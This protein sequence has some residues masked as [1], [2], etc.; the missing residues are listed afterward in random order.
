VHSPLTQGRLAQGPGDT[1]AGPPIP[2]R[3]ALAALSLATLLPSLAA[4]IANAGL[5]A[6]MQAFSASFPA[7]QW[8]VLGYLLAVTSLIVSIGRLGDRIGRRRLLLGGVALFTVA[9]GVSGAAPGLTLLIAAQAAQGF[10]AAVMTALAMTFVGDLV[11]GHK[12]GSA[13]GLLGA[14]SAIG[15]SLGPSLCGAM[16]AGPGWRAIFLINVPLGLVAFA[17]ACRYL[18]AAKGAAGDRTGFDIAGTLLL[19]VTLAAY[20]LAMTAPGRGL[21]AVLLGVAGCG[22]ALFVVVETKVAAPLIRLALFRDPA[23]NAGLAMNLLVAT[24]VMTTLVVNPFYLSH[25]LAL[26]PATAGLVLSTGPLVVALAGLPAGRLVDR[27]GAQRMTSAGLAGLSTGTLLLSWSGPALGIPGYVLPISVISLGYALFQAAN[28]TAVMGGVVAD[29]RGLVSGLLNLARSLGF[30][31]GA[32][33][34]GALF[35]HAATGPGHVVATTAA[36]ATR[37]MQTTFLAA[38]G[39]AGLALA[40][41]VLSARGAGQHGGAD[42]CPR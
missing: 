35:A 1:S 12:A 6:L 10:G 37:G 26:E 24:V 25:A 4:S 21:T 28:N 34:M 32:A 40:L 5:P 38:A 9:A 11:P 30:I 23:L 16:I 14:M 7:I 18:P 39:L 2:V 22:G 17:L 15:T 13:M 27:F 29:R 42:E 36:A 19:A 41:S 33:A 8:V 31:T 20:A 3:G